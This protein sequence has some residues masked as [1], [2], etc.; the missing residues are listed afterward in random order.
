MSL[1]TPSSSISSSEGSAFPWILEHLLAYPGT[2]EIPLRTMY[3]LNSTPHTQPFLRQNTRPETPSLCSSN[4]S[5]SDSAPASPQFPPE[6]LAAQSATEHF[7]SC[8]MS[9]ISKLPTQPFSLPPSFV[10]SFVRRCFT[11]DLCQVDFTQA[12][13][14]L[15]YLKDLES[16]RT[17]EVKT[18]LQRLGMDKDKTIETREDIKRRFP[19]VSEWLTSIAD[20]ERRVEALYTQVYVGLRRWV[21]C[22]HRSCIEQSLTM[23]LPDSHQ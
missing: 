20:K 23:L 18:A 11:A 14:A 4:D 7:K 9:H 6:Q 1:H 8:L 13:T 22:F 15:D 10:T 16:R 3:T 17:R 19:R 2:Y 21:S 5:N 12:L